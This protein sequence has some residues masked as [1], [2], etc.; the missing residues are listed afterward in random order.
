MVAM[1]ASDR[2]S[3]DMRPRVH[4]RRRLIGPW[5]SY[6]TAVVNQSQST[7][8]AARSGFARSRRSLRQHRVRRAPTRRVGR[9]RLGPARRKCRPADSSQG[10]KMI[11]SLPARL[12][13]ATGSSCL[14]PRTSS[15]LEPIL[16]EGRPAVSQPRPCAAPRMRCARPRAEVQTSWLIR[17]RQVTLTPGSRPLPKRRADT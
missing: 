6:V 7:E 15:S 1:P 5:S 9:H 12:A 3:R 2:F 10:G 17:C 16:A 13:C 14:S 8:A 11:V 4:W